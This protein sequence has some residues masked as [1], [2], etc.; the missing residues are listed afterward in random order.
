[1][2]PRSV[3]LW[4]EQL[5][6]GNAEAAQRLW[7]RYVRRINGLAKRR[8]GGHPRRTVDEE[9]V[10][11]SVFRSL[12][13][14][15]A[16]GAFPDLI[17]RNDLWPLLARLTNR[18]AVDQ[19]RRA[20][21]DK[22]G[23]GD[24]RGESALAAVD[25]EPPGGLDDVASDVN[26]PDF[27]AQMNEECDRLLAAL[28]DDTYRFVV[29]RRLEGHTNEEIAGELGIAKRSV[30]RKLQNTRELLGR[31]LGEPTGDL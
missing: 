20:N 5:K 25:G 27:A 17:D 8:F 26:S 19:I 23:G 15:A 3:T 30:E 29:W 4:I 22:R 28:P 18:K 16:N 24:V 13:L 10:A 31:M 2:P 1:M 12:F 14:G 21:R 11:Q 7:E 9:D 6:Q